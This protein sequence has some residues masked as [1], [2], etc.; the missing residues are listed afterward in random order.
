[1]SCKVAY[2]DSGV[3]INAFRG[4]SEVSIKATEIL[5]DSTR[6]FASS[7][8]VQLE[9]LPKSYY[10]KQLLE[11]EFYQTFFDAVSVWATDLNQII[12]IA[13]GIAKNYG[14]AAMDA[15]H[16]AAAIS[17]NADEFVTTEKVTKPMHRVTEIVVASIA[18]S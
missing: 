13:D 5:D 17:I 11:V 10:N 12:K 2:I 8:F 14:L 7:V 15:L 1:M 4:V 16:I 9:T 3:L 18:S 6:S